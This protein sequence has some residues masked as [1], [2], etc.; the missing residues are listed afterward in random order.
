MGRRNA[1]ERIDLITQI[2]ELYASAASREDVENIELQGLDTTYTTPS[3]STGL[4]VHMPYT[5]YAHWFLIHRML[6]RAGVEQVQVNSDIDSMTRA[7]FLTAFAE[8]VK[9]GDAHAFYVKITKWETIDERREILKA[10]KRRL[11]DFRLAAPGRVNW[12]RQS[13]HE[14]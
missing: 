11:A 4:Q 6:T 9:R 5:A 8:E 1:R 14:R 2:E 3:L 7:A 13:W 12:S 10:S